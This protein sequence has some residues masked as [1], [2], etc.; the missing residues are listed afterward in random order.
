MSE[1]TTEHGHKVHKKA[2]GHH[3]KAAHHF[4]MAAKHQLMAAKADEIDDET[5]TAHHGYLS[6]GHQI[7]AIHYAERAA[8]EDES[9]DGDD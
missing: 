6:Y 8:I 2:A 4:E 5:V 7:Q 3:R 9:V 1:N